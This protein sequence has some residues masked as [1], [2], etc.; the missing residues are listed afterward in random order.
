MVRWRA[1]P[2]RPGNLR[3]DPGRRHRHFTQLLDDAR[4]EAGESA[5]LLLTLPGT[6]APPDPDPV[7]T[8]AVIKTFSKVLTEDHTFEDGRARLLRK[9]ATAARTSNRPR[10]HPLTAITELR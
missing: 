1:I 2:R 9:H 3:P 10:L 6:Q 7:G 5:P 8:D 4:H